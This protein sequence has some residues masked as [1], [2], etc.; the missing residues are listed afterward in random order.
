MPKSAINSSFFGVI[1]RDVCGK[2]TGRR[3]KD[4]MRQVLDKTIAE[5][6]GL[7]SKVH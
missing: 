1:S 5:A 6:R 2:R 3:P 4:E 7:V